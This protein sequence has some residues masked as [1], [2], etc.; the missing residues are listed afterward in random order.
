MS[1]HFTKRF[2]RK[3][4]KTNYQNKILRFVATSCFLSDCE[5]RAQ[6]MFFH[7]FFHW[8]GKNKKTI[9]GKKAKKQVV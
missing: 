8:K 4:K 3:S 7:S 9:D 2:A 5:A 1:T 6:V